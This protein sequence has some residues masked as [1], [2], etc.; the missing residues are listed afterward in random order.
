M[1]LIFKFDPEQLD[2]LVSSIDNLS[3]NL[4]KWQGEQTAAT[5]HGFS[6]LV[7]AL[8]ATSEE[9]TQAIIDQIAAGLDLTADEVQAALNKFNQPKK[10]NDNGS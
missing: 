10:E 5:K 3:N 2:R 4:A 6:D 7:S 8:G 1:P 9:Q